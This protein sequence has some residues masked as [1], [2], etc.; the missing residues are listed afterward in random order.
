MIKKRALKKIKDALEMQRKELLSK[1]T[2]L[3]LDFDGDETDFLQARTILLVSNELSTR[4]KNKV[5]QI[6]QALQRMSDGEFGKCADCGEDINEKRLEIMPYTL[7]CIDCQEQSEKE[8]R[9]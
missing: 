7:V 3:D 6:D 1:R 5:L 8:G 9:V 2:D 4:D